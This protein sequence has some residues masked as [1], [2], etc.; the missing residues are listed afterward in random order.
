MIVRRSCIQRTIRRDTLSVAVGILGNEALLVSI[1]KRG[2]NGSTNFETILQGA[3]PHGRKGKH[4][5]L[6]TQ[7]LGDLQQLANES[8]MRIPLADYPE[9]EIAD[10][11]SAIHR[12]TAKAGLTVFTSSDDEFLYVWKP[13]EETPK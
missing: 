11:R 9:H 13:P 1:P 10:L 7:V 6:L 2:R 4:Y 12:A 8:A 5:A 3:L